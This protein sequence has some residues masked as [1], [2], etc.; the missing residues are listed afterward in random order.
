MKQ[1][2]PPAAIVAIIVVVV[3]IVAVFFMRG[4]SVSRDG[5]PPTKSDSVAKDWEK[6][7][8]GKNPGAMTKPGGN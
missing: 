8:G 1:Q 5:T 4:A 2:L 7:T 3:G 6:W